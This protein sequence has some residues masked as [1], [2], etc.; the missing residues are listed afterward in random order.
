[1]RFN[2]L[3]SDIN[4]LNIFAALIP[5]PWMQV[6]VI[7]TRIILRLIGYVNPILGI[8]ESV[9]RTNWII[10]GALGD[11]IYYLYLFVLLIND[12]N[13]QIPQYLWKK[14]QIVFHVFRYFHWI[15]Y[16][17]I[18]G[19]VLASEQSLFQI[20]SFIILLLLLCT[21]LLIK[22]RNTKLLIQKMLWI[23]F[24]VQQILIVVSNYI[25]FFARYP[26]LT[27]YFQKITHL[28]Q[29]IGF[30]DKQS[31]PKTIFLIDLTQIGICLVSLYIL[32]IK[33]KQIK[34]ADSSNDLL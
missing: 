29:F 5:L 13:K 27:S 23:I 10:D 11:W 22:V 4:I 25:Y 34:S 32:S 33:F 16:T 6:L 2:V 15:S 18:A 1:M 12:S 3:F 26:E 19:M 31:N 17:L 24:L 28:H 8:N 7:S 30:Y 21:E 14:F 20:F 9:Q